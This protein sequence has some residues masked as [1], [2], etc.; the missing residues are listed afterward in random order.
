[1]RVECLWYRETNIPPLNDRYAH[2]QIEL[3]VLVME[4][5]ALILRSDMTDWATKLITLITWLLNHEHHH[6]CV[7][8]RNQSPDGQP[9]DD[10]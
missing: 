2:L 6:V 3:D 10:E 7:P 9:E 4:L 1:M 8:S 5:N